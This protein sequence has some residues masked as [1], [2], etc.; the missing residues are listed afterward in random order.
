M[1]NIDERWGDFTFEEPQE[2]RFL[3]LPNS[4]M[5]HICR[6][7]DKT[8]DK[9]VACFI[10][11]QWTT[12]AQNVLWERP[13]FEL[14]VNFRVFLKNIQENK[15]TAL[16]VR[17]VYL[18]FLDHE[19]TLFEPIVKSTAKRHGLEGNVLSNSNFMVRV[20]KTCEKLNTLSVYGWN[21]ET[22]LLDG[23]ASTAQDLTSLHII[24]AK[25]KQQLAFNNLL[26]RLTRLRLDGVFNLNDRWASSLVNKAINLTELQ[27]SLKYISLDVLKKVCTPEK[28]ALTCLIFTDAEN[29]SD[30]YVNNVLHAFPLLTRFCLEGS[31]RVTALSILHG[32]RSCPKLNSIEIRA[33]QDS[34]GYELLGESLAHFNS[35]VYDP[36]SANPCRL[37]VENLNMDSSQ[38][39]SLSPYLSLIQ[40]LGFKNCPQLTTAA[41]KQCLSSNRFVRTF[42]SISCANIGSDLLK[43]FSTMIGVSKSLYRV[44]LE[45]SGS[46][47]PKD[48]YELCCSSTDHN[49]RQIRLVDYESIQQSA[50]G[51]YNESLPNQRH[52]HNLPIITL[53]RVSIDAIAHT[54]DPE[55]CPV[56]DDRLV[57]G[58]ALV[59]LA[60]HFKIE[61]DDL[62]DLLDSFDEEHEIAMKSARRQKNISFDPSASKCTKH[63]CI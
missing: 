31:I 53:N 3:A 16:L 42:Q 50:I 38:L 32:L 19:E 44:H 36:L 20:A 2:P 45:S 7:L 52:C 25:P 30:H 62:L 33:H 6:Y 17:D 60:D 40:T 15:K 14:P 27:L 29:M 63:L 10:H 35:C 26:S 43:A 37:L 5:E 4:V 49:L 58:S 21:L 39:I 54:T 12:A 48:I 46:V 24:G 51:N 18:A 47:D 11:R 1:K 61:L 8:S 23:L 56:P 9:Y 55:L 59:R 57:N 13:R 41:I 28:L 22:A 34:L